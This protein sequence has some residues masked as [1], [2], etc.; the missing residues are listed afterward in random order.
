[1]RIFSN[2]VGR[3]INGLARAALGDPIG[4]ALLDG[5]MLLCAPAR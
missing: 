4:G 2:I 1:M 5:S 3:L